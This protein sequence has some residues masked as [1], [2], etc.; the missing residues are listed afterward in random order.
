M[1][2]D[3]LREEEEL[4]ESAEAM[5]SQQ[6]FQLQAEIGLLKKNTENGTNATGILSN[7]LLAGELVQDSDGNIAVSETRPGTKQKQSSF[8]NEG[9]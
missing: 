7:M 6:I 4:R 2:L 5:K 8:D 9:Q 1:E 3:A